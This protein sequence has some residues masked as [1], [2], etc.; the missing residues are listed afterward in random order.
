LGDST[1][2]AAQLAASV[3]SYLYGGYENHLKGINKAVPAWARLN[4][5][6]RGDLDALKQLAKRDQPVDLPS[7]NW[8]TELWSSARST[9][10]EAILRMAEGGSESLEELQ[11]RVLIPLEA[12]LMGYDGATASQLALVTWAAL[13]PL[14]E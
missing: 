4:C 5:L 13:E 1:L 11:D 14:D 12:F 9:L 3:E 6:A 2:N 10:A 7:V 8:D